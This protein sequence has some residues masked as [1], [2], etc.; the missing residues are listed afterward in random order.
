MSNFD[1]EKKGELP[2]VSF[3]VSYGGVTVLAPGRLNTPRFVP[4]DKVRGRCGECK[5]AVLDI[6]YAVSNEGVT[7]LC[8]RMKKQKFIAF[9]DVTI[10]GGGVEG[11]RLGDHFFRVKFQGKS[12]IIPVR[13][14]PAVGETAPNQSVE[15]VD[16]ES[17]TESNPI[18]E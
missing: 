10:D 11:H 12:L 13:A 6:D 2:D 14:A 4:F 8:S 17:K 15:S 3:L 9:D 7:M 18:N 5:S 16:A 1:M